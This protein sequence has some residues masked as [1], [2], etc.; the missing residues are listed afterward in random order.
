MNGHGKG[1][2]GSFFVGCLQYIDQFNGKIIRYTL[3]KW[4]CLK[5]VLSKRVDYKF[6]VIGH[7]MYQLRK[8][9]RKLYSMLIDLSRNNVGV[10]SKWWVLL[11]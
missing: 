9:R 8:E 4:W 5:Y 1:L 10:Q 6:G 7:L 3:C 11:G 2:S